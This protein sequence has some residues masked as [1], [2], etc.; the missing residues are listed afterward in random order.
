MHLDPIILVFELIVGSSS[1]L[2]TRLEL[3]DDLDDDNLG[4]QDSESAYYTTK[5]FSAT[6]GYAEIVSDI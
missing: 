2:I 3:M 6:Q 1:Q 5:K 4:H